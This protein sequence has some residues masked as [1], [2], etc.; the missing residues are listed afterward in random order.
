MRIHIQHVTRYSYSAE[1]YPNTHY[2][3]FHPMNRP[4]LRLVDYS[5]QAD[6]QPSGLAGRLDRENNVYY[7][8]WYLEMI[9]H[10]DI[11]VEMDIEL[12]SYNPYDFLLDPVPDIHAP[13]QYQSTPDAMLQ[14]Y[15]KTEPLAADIR[16][17]IEQAISNSSANVLDFFQELNRMI[18]A[19]W[20]HTVRMEENILSPDECFARKSGSCRDLSWMLINMLR[21]RGFPSRFISGYSYVPG[22]EDGHEL[23]AWVEV[24]LPG[25]GWV[26]MDPTLGLLVTERHIPLASSYDPAHTLPVQGSYRGDAQSTMTTEV[27]ISD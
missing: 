16:N 22:M 9:S 12:N 3:Y 2:L 20:D 4:Y 8:L 14:P 10:L 15:L 19:E 24:L 1:V 27:I 26:A 23:H 11:R 21:S 17:Y 7:Q 6:P 18:A 25:A 5:I 13:F